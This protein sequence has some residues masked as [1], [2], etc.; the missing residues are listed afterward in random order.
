VQREWWRQNQNASKRFNKPRE[1]TTASKMKVRVEKDESRS[2][3]KIP[4][5]AL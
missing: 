3:D 5:G 4:G 1:D 2:L